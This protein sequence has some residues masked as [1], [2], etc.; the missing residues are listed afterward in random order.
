VISSANDRLLALDAAAW[1]ICHQAV[2]D[3][4]AQGA[5]SLDA[6]I[7]GAAHQFGLQPFDRRAV[8]ALKR[9]LATARDPGLLSRARFALETLHAANTPR[10]AAG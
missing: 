8:E 6:L 7:A 9:V 10:Q 5:S 3:L 1:P 4:F 2:R